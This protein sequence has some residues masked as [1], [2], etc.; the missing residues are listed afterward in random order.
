MNHEAHPRR[1]SSED[2]SRRR[3]FVAKGTTGRTSAGGASAPTLYESLVT[4][5]GR[6]DLLGFK[7]NGAGFA[8]LAATI[9]AALTFAKRPSGAAGRGRERGQGWS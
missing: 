2:Q 8:I 5:R 3:F 9:F 4:V 6:G 1:L 7:I